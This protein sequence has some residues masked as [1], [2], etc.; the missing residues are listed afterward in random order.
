MGAKHVIIETV[1]SKKSRQKKDVRRPYLEYYK[2][3]EWS[4]ILCTTLGLKSEKSAIEASSTFLDFFEW[5]GPEGVFEMKKKIQKNVKFILWITYCTV[6][7][8]K[9]PLWIIGTYVCKIYIWFFQTN[10]LVSYDS[11]QNVTNQTS[12]VK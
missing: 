3:N 10:L 8:F 12:N 4:G 6:F 1:T 7:H 2:N 5:S 9:S 11:K